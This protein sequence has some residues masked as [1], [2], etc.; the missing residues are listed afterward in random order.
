MSDDFARLR[1]QW[2]VAAAAKSLGRKPLG[3]TVLGTPLVLY[4]S[5]DTIVAAEDRC[6]HRNAPLSAGRVEAG[7]LRCPYHGWCFDGAGRCVEAPGL[8]DEQ[9]LQVSLRRWNAAEAGGWIWVAPAG[10]PDVP[11]LKQTLHRPA[12]DRA[13]Y[14]GFSIESDVEADLADALENLLD[15]THTPF[16]HSGLVRSASAKQLFTAVVRRRETSIEAEYRGEPQ[17][18]GLISRW[19]EPEREVS[20]G[21]FIPPCTVELEYRSRRRTELLVVANFT[22]TVAGRLRTFVTCYV[23]GGALAAILKYTLVRPLFRHVLKQDRAILEIQRRNIRRF[24]GRAYVNWQ[25]DLM[26][27]WI[28]AWLRDGRFPDQPDGPTT[29]EFRL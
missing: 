14:R 21:R 8:A 10:S 12:I 1:G 23:P 6:P 29:V 11:T 13:V 3:A 22:P 17:Q 26:R 4:R 27:P 20:F 5:D 2:F 25:A 7:R 24:G 18:S 9:A 15:G 19:F 16:V 28:D